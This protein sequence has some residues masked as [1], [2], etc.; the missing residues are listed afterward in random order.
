MT[1]ANTA[2]GRSCT[3]CTHVPDTIGN[4][5][6]V[7]GPYVQHAVN[8]TLYNMPPSSLAQAMLLSGSR[9]WKAIDGAYVV[10][11]FL[12]QDNPPTVVSYTQPFFEGNALD[13][14]ADVVNTT[15]LCGPE[16]IIGGTSTQPAIWE[17]VRLEPT[18]MAGI[19][20]TGLSPTSTLTLNVN[21]YY[22]TFP[23]PY[24]ELVTLARPSC[25]YDSAALEL[26]SSVLSSVPVGVP[27]GENWDGE[28]WADI[29]DLLLP[30]APAVG[31][32]LGGPAGAALGSVATGVGSSISSYMRAPAST[33]GKT[34]AQ[35]AA[36]DRQ[37]KK[38]NQPQQKV[39]AKTLPKTGKLS[40]AQRRKRN[41][42]TRERDFLMGGWDR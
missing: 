2:T 25:V 4:N 40:K 14:D 36:K 13:T 37:K 38:A 26:L 24:S 33:A 23:S 31:A 41:Q 16:A 28:W 30:L 17:G 15:T 12:G 18:H 20:F 32:V 19:I 10:V 35:V 42:I 9:Q 5:P 6:F 1:V 21:M 11:P 39:A 27:A 8:G 34:G 7:V 22:E 29:V 3:V